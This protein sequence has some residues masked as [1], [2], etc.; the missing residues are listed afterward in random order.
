MRRFLGLGLAGL[1]LMM[2]Q[3]ACGGVEK[4]QTAPSNPAVAATS[5][6]NAT[7]PTAATPSPTGPLNST[8]GE[9]VPDACTLLSQAT[10]AQI[11]GG[12][13]LSVYQDNRVSSADTQC[14][15]ASP[16]GGPG[17]TAESRPTCDYVAV[18][19]VAS[20]Q[21]IS[22]SDFESPQNFPSGWSIQAVSGIG[23]RALLGLTNRAAGLQFTHGNLL[24]VLVAASTMRSGSEIEPDIENAASTIAAQV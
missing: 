7:I 20:S 12:S 2:L 24:V 8:G 1:T 23:D 15:Y 13:M 4:T 6:V 5:S 16:G 18:T 14:A 22:N 11:S 21:P 10:A 9:V 3:V 19:L 17:C